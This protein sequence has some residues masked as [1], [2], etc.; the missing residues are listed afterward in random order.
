M[1][2]CLICTCMFLWAVILSGCDRLPDRKEEDEKF[3]NEYTRAVPID[4]SY[5][6]Y[7]KGEAKIPSVKTFITLE[8]PED[9]SDASD[10]I[11][12]ALDAVPAPGAVLLKAGEYKV[13]G[14]L[15]IGRN[16]VVLRG[17]GEQTRLIA[18]GTSQRTLM[19]LGIS[20]TRTLHAESALA[21]NAYVGQMW[22]RVENPSLFAVG[23]RVTV[24]L[25]P[26]AQWVT[27]LKM[28]QIATVGSTVPEQ[29]EP[30]Y[31]ATHWEREVTKIEGDKV[32]FDC[33]LVSDFEEKYAV[34]MSLYK[35]TVDR[36]EESGIEDMY[37]ISEYDPSVLDGDGNMVDESHAWTAIGV[38]GAE[39]CW[40]RGV[41]SAHF[42]YALASLGRWAR[43]ITVKDCISTAPISEITG[44]RRY[45][46][47]LGGGQ[48][49]LFENCK[50]DE[51]RHGFITGSRVPGPNV[52]LDC[53]MTNA[54][55]VVGPHHRWAT[56]LLYDCCPSGIRLEANDRAHYGSGHGWPAVNC[57]FWNCTADKIDVMSPWIGGKNYS[58]GCIGEIYQR[59]NYKDGLT[60]PSAV[61]M[62]HGVPV[63]PRSLYRAQL[64]NRKHN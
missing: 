38:A 8:A 12:K 26:N 29:W 16:G 35:V 33:P 37:L 50:A 60:R 44:S 32:W 51:D 7:R 24:F 59:I 27:D 1:K 11:Q 22:V 39:N 52:F 21:E 63:E 14:N 6:G 62:S 58:I 3:E 20:T 30:S 36:I 23:D 19:T 5:V 55:S 4:F 56:G 9:G 40:I 31:F 49:C 48:M 46:F 43:C 18:T 57:V 54:H 53:E 15:R 42:G 61:W 64:K 34:K 28:D 47:Y 10:M 45:A 25:E 17:E 2:R 13:S 41:K